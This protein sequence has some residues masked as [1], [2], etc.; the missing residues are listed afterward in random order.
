M[1]RTWIL[2]KS[3]NQKF[4][5][6]FALSFVTARLGSGKAVA[7]QRNPS[8]LITSRDKE[9]YMLGEQTYNP[10]FDMESA[11]NFALIS[12]KFYCPHQLSKA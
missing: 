4:W 11:S 3:P 7:P 10:G 5:P 9:E 2:S 6:W 12:A 1:S 8:Q